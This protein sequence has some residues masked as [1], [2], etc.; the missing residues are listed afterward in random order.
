M[1]LIGRLDNELSAR[2]FGDYLFAQGI[3][4]QIEFEKGD[5]WGLWI[6]D[7]DKLERAAALLLA[8][9]QDPASPQYQVQAKAAAGLRAEQAKGQAAYQK[10]LRNRRDLFQPLTGTALAW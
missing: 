10:R 4:N 7:E 6:R 2:T 5:G 8:F 1:R 3:E 9:R